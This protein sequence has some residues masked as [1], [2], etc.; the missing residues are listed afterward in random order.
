MLICQNGPIDKFKRFLFMRSS[1]SCVVT[2]GAIEIYA[3]QIYG[4]CA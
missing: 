1:T 2:F 3:V 4:T